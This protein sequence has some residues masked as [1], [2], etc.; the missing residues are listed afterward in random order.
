MEKQYGVDVKGDCG[1]VA[2]PCGTS[3]EWVKIFDSERARALFIR[4]IKGSIAS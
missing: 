1:W 2:Q 4:R 3:S